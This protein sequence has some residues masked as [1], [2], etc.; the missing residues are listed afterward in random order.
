MSNYAE[1]IRGYEKAIDIRIRYDNRLYEYNEQ[2]EKIKGMGFTP[3]KGIMPQYTLFLV[4]GIVN[5]M[6]F[7]GI[8]RL[9]LITMQGWF[10]WYVSRSRV[11]PYVMFM[12]VVLT[13]ACLAIAAISVFLFAGGHAIARK[14]HIAIDKY[15]Y[16]K[17][18]VNENNILK[19]RLRSLELC[20]Q[21]M[22]D[23][24]KE[25]GVPF[26]ATADDIRKMI[27]EAKANYKECEDF[28]RRGEEAAEETDAVE[29]DNVVKF[30]RWDGKPTSRWP[31]YPTRSYTRQSY[32]DDI[33]DDDDNSSRGGGSH[34]Y[35]GHTDDSSS[36]EDLIHESYE[37]EEEERERDYNEALDDYIIFH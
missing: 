32:Y 10:M 15:N 2:E 21:G 6:F 5:T 7:F 11:T 3:T 37:R 30:Q 8:V 16:D 27:E 12:A 25:N 1:K 35:Y 18:M 4:L 29:A 36:D 14:W 23:C 26:E 24:F 19:E 28:Y 34:D 20:R 17:R 9:Y 33:V 13:V 22:H 31:V